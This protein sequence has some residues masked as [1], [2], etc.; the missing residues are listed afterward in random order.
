MLLIADYKCQELLIH[1]I[2]M[3]EQG[4]VGFVRPHEMGAL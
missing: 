3:P 2:A 4:A 1:L